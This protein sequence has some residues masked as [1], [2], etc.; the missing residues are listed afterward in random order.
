MWVHSDCRQPSPANVERDMTN[1]PLQYF[2]GGPL[3]NTLV[4]ATDLIHSPRAG[5][6][7]YHW[8]PQTLTGSESGSKARIWAHTS[9]DDYAVKT[10]VDALTQ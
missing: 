10:F 4:T 2:Y 3:H 5:I 8:T 7:E 6:T 1:I 9:M